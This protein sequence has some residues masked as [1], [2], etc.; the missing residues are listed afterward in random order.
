MSN[1]KYSSISTSSIPIDM[2]ITILGKGIV[3]KSS[4]TYRFM[5]SDIPIEHDPTI[6]DRYKT[7][8]QI[9]NEE[10]TIELLDTA[11]EDGYQNMVDMWINNGDAFFLVFAINDEESFKILEKK[12]EKIIKMKGKNIP[13]VLIGNKNDL[14]N[15]REIQFKDA[16]NLAKKWG[17]DYIETSAKNNFNC[18]EALELIVRKYYNDHNER[19]KKKCCCCC[20]II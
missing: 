14:N 7:T 15:E 4:L 3:G 10:V 8:I 20:V 16:K 1:L 17:I 19:E 6:E 13:V 9:N 5:N 11:G 12:R 2:R 18:R